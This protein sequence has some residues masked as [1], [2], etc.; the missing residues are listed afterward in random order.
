MEATTNTVNTKMTNKKKK[1]L[2]VTL[3]LVLV[4]IIAIGAT[5]AWLFSQTEIKENVFTFADNISGKLDEPSWVPDDAL[6]LV[7]GK[8]IEKDPQI[9]NISTNAVT[10]YAAIRLTF[11]DGAGNTLSAS[12]TQTLLNLIDIDW[13]SNWTLYNGTLTTASGV[14]T[15][16]T[17][18][19]IYVF[20]DTLPQNV[21]SD[22]VFYSVTI[23]GSVTPD[24][25]KWLAGDYGHISDCYEYGAHD[26]DLCTVTYRHHEKCAIFGEAGKAN[27]A[28]DGTIN[29]KTCD[30][31]ATAVHEAACPTLIGTLKT[32][33]GHT[34]LVGGIG[35]FIIKVEGA[36]VQADSFDALFAPSPS[37]PG[38]SYAADA[39]VTLFD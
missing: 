25:L 16:A 21:T 3:S 38:E 27:I 32:D 12:D 39:L 5:L 11:Q 23:K 20:N 15:A 2:T 31:T 13:S 14:V 6:E 26:G 10:E 8:K 35:N 24:Q 29:G 7:P 4:A 33:C 9:T 18:E 30:C 37:V 19:Q 22:P 36:V 28:Q 34:T 1:R 17:A